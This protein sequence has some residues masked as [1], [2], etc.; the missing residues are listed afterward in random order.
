MAFRAVDIMQVLLQTSRELLEKVYI[1]CKGLSAKHQQTS[2]MFLSTYHEV[3][4]YLI[5]PWHSEVASQNIDARTSWKYT[6]ENQGAAVVSQIEARLLKAWPES[7]CSINLEKVNWD[8]D[9]RAR[10][11]SL[12]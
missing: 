6:I 5:R 10:K 1:A 12:R 9:E 4:P 3:H 7:P 2:Q 11:I 8:E